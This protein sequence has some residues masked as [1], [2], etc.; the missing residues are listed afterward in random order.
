[1]IINRVLF[2]IF[3]GGFIVGGLL[4]QVKLAKSS[5]RWHGYVLPGI[6]ALFTVLVLLGVGLYSPGHVDSGSEV[7]VYNDEGV[8]I[9]T[10]LESE[11]TQQIKGFDGQFIIQIVFQLLSVGLLMSIPII[12]LLLINSSVK[13]NMK[14]ENLK[15]TQ[16]EKMN[17]QDL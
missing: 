5:V 16:L 12:I 14:K 4:L 17:I 7:I 13:N 15:N 1:M 11:D 10:Y 3:V 6:C 2:I 8:V 9:D